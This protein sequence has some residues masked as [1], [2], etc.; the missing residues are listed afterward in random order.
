MTLYREE[1]L[2]VKTLFRIACFVT[3]LFFFCSALSGQA[4]ADNAPQK[5]IVILPPVIHAAADFS[6][7]KKGV[8][9][10]LSSRLTE[11]GGAAVIPLSQA[12]AEAELPGDPAG[13]VSLG[14]RMGVDFV[15]LQS[16]TVIG[17]SVS[18]DAKVVDMST[19]QVALS[20]GRAGSQQSDLIV[21]VDQ[22]A[23]EINAQLF[24]IS[25]PKTANLPA[26]VQAQPAAPRQQT[27]SDDIHLHPE[28][29]LNR[30]V[31]GQQEDVDRGPVGLANFLMRSRRIGAELQGIT[32]GDVD[33]DG[34]VDIVCIG[35]STVYIYTVEQGQFIKKA[36]IKSGGAYIGVDAADVNGNGRAEIFVT[37]YD[38]SGGRLISFVLEYQD[39]TYQ[40]LDERLRWY[41]RKLSWPGRGEILAGQRQG[42]DG[43]FSAGIYE[44][45]YEGGS[46]DGVA[47]LPLPGKRHLFGIGFGPVQDAGVDDI[48]AFDSRDYVQILNPG[49]REIWTSAERYGGSANAVEVK[50]E[51]DKM[52]KDLYYMPLRLKLF[53]M[54]G[55]GRQEIFV[56]S[57]EISTG[58]SFARVRLFKNGRLEA[59]RWDELGLAP[60]WRTRNMAKHISD[61][62]LVDLTG[63][64]RP[65]AVAAVVQKDSSGLGSGN[66]YLAVFE[67]GALS[68]GLQ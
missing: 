8:V 39:G 63:D 48:V 36:E 37:N 41:F 35:D 52:S 53:D 59:L 44:I 40:R 10:M 68:A 66:S 57:N 61:F 20:F 31:I 30:S 22:L 26:P 12:G 1:D 14:R 27:P 15:V 56:V 16:I 67:I 18:T 6:Y 65:E 32:S 49:G 13:A 47:K 5:K 3:I 4:T 62:V 21:H 9:D 45:G 58:R 51:E 7:L 55:D 29:L 46:Y 64:Q 34:Q 11:G 19:G 54:D 23:A 24:G 60:V 43:L 2:T 38:N 33:G 25:P 17:N 50:T 42:V 28:K